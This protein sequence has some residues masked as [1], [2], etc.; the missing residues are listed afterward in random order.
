MPD[1]NA[2]RK[3]QHR[4]HQTE[5]HRRNLRREENVFARFRIGHDAGEWRQ[6]EDGNLPGESNQTKQRRGSGQP[7]DKPRLGDILYV[8]ADERNELATQE[9]LKISIFE[10]M[11]S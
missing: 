5:Q 11:K 4:K 2:A 10:R 3:R 9:E 6:H 8:S 7:I 1:L